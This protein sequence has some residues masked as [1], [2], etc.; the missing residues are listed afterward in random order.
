MHM[1]Q[2]R[3]WLVRL[4]G[5]FHRKL[6]EREFA[7]ELES[8]LAFHIEDNLRAGVSPEE[9]RRQALVK[10][11]GVTQIQELHREQRGLPMLET[12][13]QDLRF[14]LRM[15]HRNPGFSL[16]AILT[17]ALGIGAN[18]AIFSVVNAVLLKPLPYPE[19]G[20]LAQL[21][22]VRS[23]KPDTV[24]GSTAFVQVKAQSQ[25]LARVAAYVGGDMT[26]TGAGSAE[27]VVA[28]AVTADFFP[29]LGIQP[30]LG[31][32]FTQEED[33]PNG[34]KAAILGHGLWQSRFGG[35]ADVLGRTIRLN[36]QSYTVVGILPAHFQYPEPF[37]LWIPLALSETSAALAGYGEGMVLLKAIA[38]LKPG[39]TLQQAQA[40][41]QTIGQRIQPATPRGNPRQR[42]EGGEGGEGG[43]R[44]G[45]GEGGGRGDSVLTLIGLHE[46]VVGDV[47]GALLVLLGAVALVLLIAC[48]NVANLLLARAAARQREM[49]IRAALGAGRLRVARQLLTESVLLSLAGG[50]LGL[51]MAF[52]G[53]R[54]LGQWSGASL[55]AM[56]GIGIDA[57]VL[58]FTLGVSVLTGLAFGLAPA[59][60]AWRTDVNAALKEE[61]RGDT[62]GHRHWLRHLLVVS[63]VA[64][65]LVLLIGAGLLIKS[66]SR[67][68][69]V[70]PG[71]R[72]DDVLTFQV[73]LAE[74]ESSPQ[75]VIF[76][77]Q[78]VERLKALPG[79]QAA[80]ATDS[81]PLTDF[82]RIGVAEIEGRPPID[83]RKA[84]R[85][86]VTPYSRP[87]V[88]LDY[89]NAMG[90]PLRNGRAFTLQDARSPAE[91][92]I[93][94]E[95][96]EKHHFPGQSAVG[97]RIRLMARGTDA[98]WQTV[99]GVVS[100][101]RQSGLAGDVMSEV[102]SPELEDVGGE[103]S[104]VIRATGEPASL[105][106]AVRRVVAEVEPNQAIHN[107]MTMEQR[108]A[109]TTT[110]QRLN[111][112]LL[113]SFAGLALLLAVVGIYGVMSYAVTQRRREIGVRMAMG[114]Q[115]GDVL[116]L[117]IGEGMKLV[118]SGALLGLGGA[119]A[120]TRLLKTLL[121][122]VSA[123]DPLTFI[124][125]AALL[126]IV[127]L[128]ACWI[129]ARRATRGDPMIAL[130]H[131]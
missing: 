60:Q 13:I 48:A 53:V 57:W 38:R 21:R 117:V 84:K 70:N 121:F 115:T 7:E 16:V 90:I 65:A 37:Q 102:Y 51:V 29:L 119:L 79:V 116:R 26:L 99:V 114:A 25:L 3:G 22:I 94:N 4:F 78:V 93:V 77:K 128:L 106:S 108:L 36:E 6:R 120:L 110:S 76:I 111:T 83:L 32:N 12:L 5:L 20:Q 66:F 49:A 44:G 124:V 14:G 62:G 41:L 74:G 101:V 100:D 58:A 118:L 35:A 89:F 61:G 2:L 88:T 72:T 109:N 23:G 69:D 63:E 96:F 33:T 130:R 75:K 73:T 81:L 56:H 104:F 11:G 98:R 1:R 45:R 97:K 91:S 30:T 10:L 92:V 107:V 126:I 18:T 103:L 86:D 50:G 9:A 64:L 131:E 52:W 17:L 59:I 55:P 122:G 31:R 125:I 47:K 112:I 82:S 87:T 80:A 85:S 71:F 28:G 43:E 15:L 67:L 40:E 68:R 42:G 95:A 8:H 113:G 39:V 19:P 27:G 46:Q 54:A 105:I 34:P 127:A 123:T 129:P 24:I